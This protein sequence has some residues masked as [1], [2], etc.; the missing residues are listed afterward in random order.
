MKR[1]RIYG[2]K[3]QKGALNMVWLFTEAGMW[4]ADISTGVMH[5]Y[6]LNDSQY[7]DSLFDIRAFDIHPDGSWWLGIMGKGV[8]RYDPKSKK[9]RPCMWQ[10]DGTDMSKLLLAPTCLVCDE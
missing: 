5:R 4:E 3:S 6:L 2:Y 9:L 10:S 7:N 1:K 8:F